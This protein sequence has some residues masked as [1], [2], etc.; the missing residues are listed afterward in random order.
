MRGGWRPLSVSH[1]P[2]RVEGWIN[3]GDKQ[4]MRLGG[5]VGIDNK[6][7]FYFTIS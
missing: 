6:D 7:F 3:P 5:R 2:I 1:S 4:R